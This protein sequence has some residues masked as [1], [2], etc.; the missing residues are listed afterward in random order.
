[1]Q[2]SD[3]A[4]VVCTKLNQLEVEDTAA[5]KLFAARRYEMI[6]QDQLWKDSV[7]DWTYTLPAV[8]TPYL[9]TS[10]WLPTKQILIL[11]AA[12]DKVLAVRTGSRRMNVQSEEI[13]F[14]SDVDV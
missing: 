9:S 12:F 14:R 8:G 5:A 2:L 1:M 7:I 10:Q 4:N 11:P 6:W 3:I 13:F